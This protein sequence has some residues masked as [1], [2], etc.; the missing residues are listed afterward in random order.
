MAAHRGV[1][2]PVT[3]CPPHRSEALDPFPKRV[4]QLHRGILP[5]ES[6]GHLEVRREHHFSGRAKYREPR[7]VK[8]S[9]PTPSSSAL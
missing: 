3:S 8:T 1:P 6:G 2:E 9:A 4:R 5:T 7:S